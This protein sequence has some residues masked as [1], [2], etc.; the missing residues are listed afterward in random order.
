MNKNPLKVCDI[1]HLDIQKAT[2]NHIDNMHK[3][4]PDKLVKKNSLNKDEDNLDDN[5]LKKR[6]KRNRKKKK[7]TDDQSQSETI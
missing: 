2:N 4:S 1:N 5:A 6:K 7:K 3:Y